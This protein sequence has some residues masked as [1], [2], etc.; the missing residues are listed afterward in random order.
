M[1]ADIVLSRLAAIFGL[2][3]ICCDVADSASSQAPQSGKLTLMRYLQPVMDAGT[4]LRL[5]YAAG[6]DATPTFPP[7]P[8]IRS[9]EPSSRLTGIDAVRSIFESDHNV[10]V[11]KGHNGLVSISVGKV[12]T[13]LL[14]TRI[15]LLRLQPIEQYNPGKV[16]DALESTKELNSAVKSLGLV[17]VAPPHIELMTLPHN[18][19]P[20]VPAVLQNVTVDQVLDM[21]ARTFRR[22]VTYGVCTSGPAPHSILISL[23]SPS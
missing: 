15:P 11:T 18:G 3:L 8:P 13:D 2:F 21:V 5:T 22:V 10:M 6:C 23:I 7:I 20:H 14:R 19:A 16:I 12:P 9:S 4:P 1:M 17:L